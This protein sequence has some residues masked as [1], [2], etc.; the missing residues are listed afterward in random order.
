MPYINRGYR[1]KLDP[2]ISV[3]SEKICETAQNKTDIFGML[4]YAFT[5]ISLLVIESTYERLQYWL[6]AELTG[7]LHNI[8]DEFYRRVVSPYED[9][10]MK[11]SG[12]VP[13]YKQ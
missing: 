1:E 7:I 13:E 8:S 5:R 10:K 11:E 3:L 2:F 4:N 9:N 12:D 6:I